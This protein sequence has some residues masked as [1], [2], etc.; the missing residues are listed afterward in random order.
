MRVA[1]RDDELADAKLLR[2]AEF[3]RLEV[4]SVG[5][6]DGQVG[7]W[8]RP[9]DLE[10]ELTAVDERRATV[11]FRSGD[12]VRGRQHEPVRGDGDGAATAVQDAAAPDPSRNAEV[13]NGRG[14]P[15]GDAGHGAGVAIERLRFRDLVRRRRDEGQVHCGQ[16]SN[17]NR[18]SVDLRKSWR[19]P[20][21]RPAARA[22]C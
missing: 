8:I 7:Q 6:E 22:R 20:R 16:A 2:I 3:R 21:S 12:D 17:P 10:F 13:R 1:D 14:E 9:D 11:T 15:L 19:W 4:A 5:A 18:F